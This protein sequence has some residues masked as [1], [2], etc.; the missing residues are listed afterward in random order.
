VLTPDAF[1]ESDKTVGLALGVSDGGVGSLLLIDGTGEVVVA[2]L[3]VG[4]GS[5]FVGIESTWERDEVLSG[6]S[7]V[8]SVSWG[9]F[10][11][12]FSVKQRIS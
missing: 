5:G 11:L 8:L 2:K 10:F 7:G 3:F 9:L 4:V 6:R 12:Y 1:V